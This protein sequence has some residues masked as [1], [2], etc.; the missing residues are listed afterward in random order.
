MVW[1]LSSDFL[2]FSVVWYERGSGVLEDS[3]SELGLHH[4]RFTVYVGRSVLVQ[5]KNGVKVFP[6]RT[7]QDLEWLGA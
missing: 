2:T 6:G 7:G 5:V 4:L 3:A 1:D